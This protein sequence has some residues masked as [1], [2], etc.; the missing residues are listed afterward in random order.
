MR[1]AT[2][3]NRLTRPS[4]RYRGNGYRPLQPLDPILGH[5]HGHDVRAAPP[6]PQ[7]TARIYRGA[8]DD[9]SPLSAAR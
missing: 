7:D 1:G 5:G 2:L 6:E 9:S 4:R 3:A 8:S